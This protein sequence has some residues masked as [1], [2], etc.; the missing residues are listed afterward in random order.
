MGRAEQLVRAA[1]ARSLITT[2]LEDHPEGAMLPD[3]MQAVKALGYTSTQL[4]SLL[5]RMA[6]NGLI[7]KVAVDNPDY[8]YGYKRA[9][10]ISGAGLGKLLAEPKKLKK[11]RAAPRRAEGKEIPIDVRANRDGS[12][13]VRFNGLVLRLS[14]E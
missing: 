3:L 7:Q 1:K 10:I 4:A 11:E 14:R 2:Y 13:T 12:C 9:T 8:K 6:D 5:D